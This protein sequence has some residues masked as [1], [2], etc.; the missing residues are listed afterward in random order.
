MDLPDGRSDGK[1]EVCEVRRL[2]L[3]GGLS[4]WWSFRGLEGRILSTCFDRWAGGHDIGCYLS[5]PKLLYLLVT[6]Q[7]IRCHCIEIFLPNFH[8]PRS[9][10]RF[11]LLL[12]PFFIWTEVVALNCWVLCCL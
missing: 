3:F 5:L 4:A 7:G 12:C 10:L 6:G 9:S 11:C 1:M 8:L 2:H